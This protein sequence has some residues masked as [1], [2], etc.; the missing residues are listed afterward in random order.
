MTS[1]GEYPDAFVSKLTPAGSG[2]EYSTYLGGAGDDSGLGIAVDARGSAHVTGRTSSVDFPTT[3]GAFDTRLEGDS[4]GEPGA[5]FVTKL[6]PGGTGV[7]YS[8]YLGGTG[9]GYG[10]GIALG[11]GGSAYVGG[12]TASADFPTTAGALDRTYD[13]SCQYESQTFVT[14]LTSNGARLVYST[15]LDEPSCD[16]GSGIAVDANGSAYVSGVL[17]VRRLNPAGSRITYARPLVSSHPTQI[18]VDSSGDAYVTGS[19][20]MLASGPT[21]PATPGA[22]DT[23]LDGFSDAFVAKL[24]VP[25]EPRRVKRCPPKRPH[26][27]KPPK[28]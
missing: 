11:P 15:Y 27:C 23:G 2:L 21:P 16:Q 9:G 28:R 6:N 24:V 20:G 5:A 1:Q 22:F 26:G 14:R 7:A 13:S 8:T 19:A 25:P 3:A 4:E 17:A 10:T 12:R 18:A